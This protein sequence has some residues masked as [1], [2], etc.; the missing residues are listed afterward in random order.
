MDC[1]WD[2]PWAVTISSHPQSS[3]THRLLKMIGQ[4]IP[5]TCD[6][7]LGF[8]GKSVTGTRPSHTFSQKIQKKIARMSTFCLGRPKIFGDC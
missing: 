2:H 5:H 1:R 4:K 8:L 3:D 7:L 6:F